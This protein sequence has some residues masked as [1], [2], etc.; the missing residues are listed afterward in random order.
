MW[1]T[2]SYVT[3]ERGQLEVCLVRREPLGPG[4]VVPALFSVNTASLEAQG[5]FF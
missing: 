4:L 1:E 2:V 5:I 3:P